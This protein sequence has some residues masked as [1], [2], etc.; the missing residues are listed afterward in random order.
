MKKRINFLFH[1]WPVSTFGPSFGS[2]VLHHRLL[3]STP[4]PPLVFSGR[5]PVRPKPKPAPSPG[6]I[7]GP[8][9]PIR[10]RARRCPWRTRQAAAAAPGR[11]RLGLLGVRAYLRSRARALAHLALPCPRRSRLV[12]LAPPAMQ[13]CRPPWSGHR[14]FIAWGAAESNR[15]RRTLRRAE[16]HLLSFFPRP[17]KHR[18]I[19]PA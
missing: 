15:P 6:P 5:G 10:A 1:F 13:P 11:A 19:V 3:F 14:R 8:L 17:G 12:L 2:L 16:P 18:S 4:S 7:A 9:E